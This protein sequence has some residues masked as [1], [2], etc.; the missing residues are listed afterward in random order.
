MRKKLSNLIGEK[1]FMDEEDIV[2][3]TCDFN[4]TSNFVIVNFVSM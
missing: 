1:D 3:M 2:T 4:G